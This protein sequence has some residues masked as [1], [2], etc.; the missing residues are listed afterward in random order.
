MD[1]NQHG[2]RSGRSTLSQ[3]LEQQDEI[4]NMLE[5]R[6]NVGMIYLDFTKAFDKCD[7]GILLKKIKALGIKG[8]L[9]R[10]ILSI[11]MNRKQQVVV[12]GHK[13]GISSVI[14]GVPQGSVL[15]PILFL[16]YISDNVERVKSNMKIY[17][18]DSK[19]KEKIRGPED[20][21][22]LQENLEQLYLWGNK[23]TCSLMEQS[24]KCSDLE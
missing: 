18:D 3:L 2:S 21:E 17:V 24:S 9:G 20:V 5:E 12:R 1:P 10:W 7:Y 11:L 15:G 8:R 16:I 23:I 14:S 13:S 6:T 22:L 19:T 4:L